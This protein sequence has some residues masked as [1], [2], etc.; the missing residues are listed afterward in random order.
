MIITARPART[1]GPG[2]P[3]ERENPRRDD[4][5]FEAATKMNSYNTNHLKVET[6][7]KSKLDRG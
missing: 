3:G 5:S 2:I 1:D 6:P 7:G 4:F